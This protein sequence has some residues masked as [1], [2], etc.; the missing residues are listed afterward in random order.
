MGASLRYLRKNGRQ[1][2]G[3]ARSRRYDP[4][5]LLRSVV[6]ALDEQGLPLE[7]VHLFTFNQI[8]A[9]AAWVQNLTPAT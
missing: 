9:T 6:A 1:M 3:L 4:T 8:E 2:V 7:G 5:P